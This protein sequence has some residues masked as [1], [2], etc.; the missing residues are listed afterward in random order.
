M[1]TCTR[2]LL[3]LFLLAAA[4][5][6]ADLG[7]AG[8]PAGVAPVP[9]VVAPAIPPAVSPVGTAPARPAPVFSN[10]VSPVAVVVSPPTSSAAPGV[11]VTA[12]PPGD[13]AAASTETAG[14]GS[15]VASVTAPIVE[16]S[17][18]GGINVYQQLYTIYTY[19]SDTVSGGVS[20][21]AEAAAVIPTGEFPS[22][23]DRQEVSETMP[24][25]EPPA[26]TA[27]TEAALVPVGAAAVDR[28][29]P[30]ETFGF[31]A[32]KSPETA[33]AYFAARL[34]GLDPTTFRPASSTGRVRLPP[35]HP[36]L[37]LSSP[38]TPKIP[39]AS[40]PALI[41]FSTKPKPAPAK[42]PTPGEIA[43]ALQSQ[44]GLA[45]LPPSPFPDPVSDEE[46]AE[47]RRLNISGTKTFEMKKAD[48]KGDL[49]HF[50]TENYDSIP[51]FH[52]DQS[53]HLEIDGNI[54][55][56]AKVSAVLDD[57]EDEDRRFTV[58][59]DGP[60]W[61][62]TMG[63]F[64]LG[65][66]DTEFQLF[67]KE[68][69][70]LMAQGDVTENLQAMFLYSQSK[71][72][73]RREQFRGAGQQQEFRLAV[74]PVVQNSEKV[75]ID[76]RLMTRG[77]DYLVDYEDGV[78]KFLPHVLPI[79]VTS[80]IVIEYEVNDSKMAFKRNLYGTRLLSKHGEG[81]RLGLS[82][83]RELDSDTPKSETGSSTVQPMQHDLIGFDGD[84]RLTDTLSLSG[85]TALSLYDPNRLSDT[86]SSDR[87]ITD[88]AMRLQLRAKTQ[89]LTGDLGFRRVGK[90]FRMVGR[91]GGVTE[92]GERGLANDILKG[93]GRVTWQARPKLQLFAGLESSKTNLS[94]DP[95]VS[96]IEFRDMNGGAAY[97]YRDRSR[98]E[99]RYGLQIDE[100]SLRG[101]VT[102]RDKGVGAVVWDHEFGPVFAQSKIEHTTYDDGVNVASGSRILNVSTSIG[103]D[104][105][106]KLTW[107]A[108]ASR[109][110][111]DDDI[112]LNEERSDTRNYTLDLNYEP[113]RA[114]NAR[115][116]LEWRTEDDLL[117]NSRQTGQIADSRI[118]YQ[119]SRDW[120]NQFKYKVEN[121]SKVIR[122]A[123]LDPRRYVVPTSLPLS[124]DEKDQVLTRFENPVQKSTSNFTTSWRA[125]DKVETTFD[126]KRRDLKDRATR[127]LVSLNDRKSYEVRYTPLRKLK[128]TGEYEDG[129]MRASASGS[130]LLDTVR[131]FQVR[132]EFFEGYI[133][134]ML[135]EDLDENDV[136]ADANDKRTTGKAI[137]FQRIFSPRATLEA[138]V[139]RNVIRSFQPSKEWETRAAFV[140]TPS[141]R[142][143]RYRLFVTNKRID[144]AKPGTHR[145]GGL[146]FSQFIGSDSMVEG[147]VKRVE[148]T[149]GLLGNGY[150]GTV[151]N[152]KMIIS[153]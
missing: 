112:D 20:R 79:E 34:P 88:H 42:P 27:A 138:G 146:S 77:S 48:V 66:A 45:A 98:V 92:L 144:S 13:V 39:A 52:L 95:A 107:T 49:G 55:K 18:G 148:S 110:T 134:D 25:A 47:E 35:H 53:M 59:L 86:A 23:P 130:K 8:I 72:R 57:K 70:G 122:D 117:V 33:K 29:A 62:L 94:N 108:G 140:L 118:R 3:P 102:D 114:L 46:D 40:D 38:S 100:E 80:W 116:I 109:M 17:G 133:I 21:M 56:S 24:P 84:W 16:H 132:N 123:S 71:G 6:S 43:V 127:L 136:Y 85:E 4:A 145:E 76:G 75:T 78:I 90:D 125:G 105:D 89:T 32:W 74:Q 63:D 131:R 113:S 58:N 126:W 128:L 142:N 137:D 51:G 50:S 64:P 96:R 111:L 93:S 7:P 36:R 26:A 91:E 147:E 104:R 143:Q 81:R 54:T 22:T 2:F 119:P 28:V 82:W 9:S 149:A 68:V 61:D 115:G 10:T 73:A 44:P 153:F 135:W 67:R 12:N 60:V 83:L 151:A 1:R 152:A 150:E 129:E 14:L 97:S 65:L 106:K 141:A 139:Q 101:P 11:A 41:P 121:T 120:T 5:A 15:P 30:V 37:P 103:S 87:T 124:E 31:K 99:A 69:R 19:M